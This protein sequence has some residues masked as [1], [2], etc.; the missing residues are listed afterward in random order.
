MKVFRITV[1]FAWRGKIRRFMAEVWF[2]RNWAGNFRRSR[3]ERGYWWA[4]RRKPGIV[5]WEPGP[6]DL[7]FRSSLHE[8]A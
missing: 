8:V 4:W 6:F 2:D 5:E 1:E 7:H 3:H